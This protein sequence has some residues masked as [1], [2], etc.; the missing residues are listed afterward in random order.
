[1]KVCSFGMIPRENFR[2][3][4]EKT[5][6]LLTGPKFETPSGEEKEGSKETPEKVG[7]TRERQGMQR[8]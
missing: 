7:S 5:E 8:L 3:H 6:A 2:V 1:M 4:F